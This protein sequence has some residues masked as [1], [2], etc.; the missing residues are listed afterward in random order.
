MLV[1]CLACVAV[2][3][4]LF[5]QDLVVVSVMLTTVTFWVLSLAVIKRLRTQLIDSIFALPAIMY[6]TTGL[7]IALRSEFVISLLLITV[8]PFMIFFVFVKK[9]IARLS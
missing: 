6:L 9:H 1:G 8:G 5:Q 7:S 3:V 2:A 4:T